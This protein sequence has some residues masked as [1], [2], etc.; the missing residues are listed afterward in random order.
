MNRFFA[1]FLLA[2]FLGLSRSAASRF[3]DPLDI[4]CVEAYCTSEFE[5]C[6]G[7]PGCEETQKCAYK[8]WQDWD[9]DTTP[10]KYVV[11]N[12]TNKC[13]YSYGNEVYSNFMGCINRRQCLVLPPLPKTCKGPNNITFSQKIS[14]R[15]LIGTW[16]NLKGYNPVYDCYPC[17]ENTFTS[18]TLTSKFQAFLDNGGLKSVREVG[19][20]KVL[21]P[22]PGFIVTQESGGIRLE[23]T[24]WPFDRV[25]E[26]VGPS[27]YLV[28]YCG[29]ANE[30]TYEGALVLSKSTA[31][32][33]D[34]A[35]SA[36]RTSF[37]KNV[38]LDLDKF[39]SPSTKNC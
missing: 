11:Q 6:E 30:W 16:W 29:K 34:R 25:T 26:L 18:L 10:Q 1:S 37:Q 24:L 17:Q 21:D 5:I 19:S 9:A 23:T 36:I 39:C 4:A 20:I 12:C 31:A 15:D 3:P 13:V 38:G 2:A 27:Y 22:N 7:D 28:Y 33:P 32:I 8:C 14:V 35:L